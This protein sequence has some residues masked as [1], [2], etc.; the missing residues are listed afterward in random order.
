MRSWFKHVSFIAMVMMVAAGCGG[1]GGSTKEDADAGF[2]IPDAAGADG[3]LTGNVVT[4]EGGVVEMPGGAV[5][6]IPPG[7][8]AKSVEIN[9]EGVEVS[10]TGLFDAIGP[11]YDFGPAGL[12]FQTPASLELPFPDHS[13]VDDPVISRIVAAW[14]ENGSDWAVVKGDVDFESRVITVPVF[15]FS[16]GGPAYWGDDPLPCDDSDDCEDPLPD[17]CWATACVDGVCETQ[18]LE[19]GTTCNTHNECFKHG[20]CNESGECRGKPKLCNQFPGDESCYKAGCD[21][22]TGQCEYTL[23][24]QCGS[25][26]DCRNNAACNNC[27]CK[28]CTTDEECSGKSV[29]PC[30]VR[31][32]CSDGQCFWTYKAVGTACD[33][34]DPCTKDDMCDSDGSCFGTFI[35]CNNPPG[36]PA[37]YGEGHCSWTSSNADRCEYELVDECGLD[38]HCFEGQTCESC[39]CVDPECYVS[40]DCEDADPDDCMIALCE[41][42]EC[43]AH[44]D[45]TT[46]C[47]D[48]NPCTFEDTCHG[49]DGCVGKPEP[50]GTPCDDGNLETVETTCQSGECVCRASCEDS[51]CGDDGC[52]GICGTCPDDRPYCMDG[53][54]VT[55]E[56]CEGD[57]SGKQCGDDGCGSSCGSCGLLE[58]CVDGECVCRPDCDDRECGPDGC[59]DTCGE[60]DGDTPFCENGVCVSDCENDCTDKECGDDG[61]GGSCGTCYYGYVCVDNVCRCSPDCQGKECGDDGCGGRCGTCQV[62]WG[63]LDNAC[64]EGALGF[65]DLTYPDQIYRDTVVEFTITGSNL[66]DTLEAEFSDAPAEGP[67]WTKQEQTEQVFTALFKM[68]GD[69]TVMLRADP[70]GETLFQ[71]DFVVDDEPDDLYCPFGTSICHDAVN[72]LEWVLIDLCHRTK[73]NFANDK[74]QDLSW[75]G[76]DDWRLPTREELSSLVTGCSL[77][78]CPYGEGPGDDGMYS[79]Q[80]IDFFSAYWTSTTAPGENPDWRPY[81]W[82]VDFSNGTTSA[83]PHAETRAECRCVRNK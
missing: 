58:T 67:T 31:A 55:K 65:H 20:T 4:P 11:F 9:V 13:F 12:E 24:G 79:P 42:Y 74:C 36:D 77:P 3:G 53:Q 16:K 66:P 34:G 60:C 22:A 18:S 83:E 52:G 76:N 6:R 50:N 78:P 35:S 82:V 56:D 75:E 80:V 29:F 2:N 17:D 59:G 37:C 62:G 81:Y 21:P 41:D 40:A 27:L 32:E 49:V 64:A 1:G 68:M 19:S 38:A 10:G 54:C 33:D 63:C 61:C 28:H 8:L 25:A 48:G 44:G 46:V 71:G 5:L 7:A 39:K 43:T 30:E 57:C 45:M 23:E 26:A 15:G 14:S 73:W 70:G 51:E 69:N 72:G 47:D